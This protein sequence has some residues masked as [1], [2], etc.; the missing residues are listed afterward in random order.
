MTRLTKEREIEIDRELA[1]ID[2][3][4]CSDWIKKIAID[5]RNQIDAVRAENENLKEAA[6]IQFKTNVKLRGR[7]DKLREAIAEVLKRWDN[8]GTN[9]DDDFGEVGEAIGHLRE[10][11]L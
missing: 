5:L 2:S 1:I 8:L 3:W 6:I 9:K 4:F 7:I 11:I 10:A